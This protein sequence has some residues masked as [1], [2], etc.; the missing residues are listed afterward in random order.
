MPVK[1]IGQSMIEANLI[2]QQQ[3]D[4]LLEYQRQS[5]DRVPLGKLT[6]DLGLVKEDEFVPFL[7]SYFGVPYINL[8]IYSNIQKEALDIVPEPIAK[9]YN[10]L[11]ITK[12]D[13]TLTIAISD[14]LDLTTIENLETVTH[15]RIK[16]V[17]S[18]SDQIRHGIESHYTG[19]F[20]RSKEEISKT[21]DRA[22]FLKKYNN[23]WPFVSSL[24]GLLVEKAVGN[25][26]NLIHIQPE[27]NRM[28][29]F[30]RVDKKL[31]KVASYPR[32]VFK[33]IINFIKKASN[34][35]LQ[36]SDVPQA[37]CF[38]Y[39]STKLNIEI[40]VSIFPTLS[41][42]RVVLEVP[43]R[44]GWLDEESWIKSIN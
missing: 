10:V 4:D 2:N 17:V 36:K 8:D 19:V 16:Q 21:K 11:P 22:S 43:R 3:L 1:L 15:C 24:V 18:T 13:D 6:V 41:G 37:G 12:E 20:L 38:T 34:L 5:V 14:P 33:P 35:N 29:V 39:S 44:I 42:E 9:R 28:K 26:I 23:N 40:G 32:A 25:G 27:E 7:A 31:S 30:F